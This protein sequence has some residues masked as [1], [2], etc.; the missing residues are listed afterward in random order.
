V[1][2]TGWGQE[3]DR[4]RSTEAGFNAHLVKPVDHDVLMKLIASLPSL[5]ASAPGPSGR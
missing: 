2:L 4:D 3:E 5:S 1:A